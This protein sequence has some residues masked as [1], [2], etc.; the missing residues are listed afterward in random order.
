MCLDV[1]DLKWEPITAHLCT[2]C[3]T[4]V[5]KVSPLEEE[6]NVGQEDL[7]DILGVAS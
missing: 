3:S 1:A 6:V 2:V 4:F 5:E 7:D